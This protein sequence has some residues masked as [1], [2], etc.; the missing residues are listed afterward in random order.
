MKQSGWM[1]NLA[2]RR[3]EYVVAKNSHFNRHDYGLYQGPKRTYMLHDSQ[4]HDTERSALHRLYY[5]M[6]ARHEEMRAK[7]KKYG[8]ELD[9]I[10]A[11]VTALETPQ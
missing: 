9:S 3:V 4:V 2:M 7:L 6:Q 11:A 1:V 5:R 10:A 8:T